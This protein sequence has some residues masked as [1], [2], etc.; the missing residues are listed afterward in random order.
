MGA[1]WHHT[2]RIPHDAH[3]GLLSRRRLGQR[4]AGAAL[5]SLAVAALQ[6]VEPDLELL[7]GA[8]DVVE[9]AGG[10]KVLGKGIVVPVVREGV[11]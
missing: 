6:L 1:A 5:P 2:R 8:E 11:V 4:R 10:A 7:V 3:T 9:Q